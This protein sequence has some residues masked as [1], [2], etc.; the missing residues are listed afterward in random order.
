MVD[1]SANDQVQAPEQNRTAPEHRKEKGNLATIAVS[2]GAMATR[3][4]MKNLFFIAFQLEKKT[5]KFVND[6]LL[7]FAETKGLISR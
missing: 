1:E 2:P 5:K 4:I 7:K 6:G 3:D